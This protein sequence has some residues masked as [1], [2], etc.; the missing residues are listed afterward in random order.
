MG[1]GAA[2]ER[3][4][5][6]MELTLPRKSKLTLRQ[7]KTMLS[8]SNLCKCVIDIHCCVK[9][10]PGKIVFNHKINW[11]T[12]KWI[13]FQA[14]L[15]NFICCT[16]CML[17]WITTRLCMLQI[18]L[19]NNVSE[20]KHKKKNIKNICRQSYLYEPHM[21]FSKGCWVMQNGLKICS[22]AYKGIFKI[23]DPCMPT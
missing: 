19:L 2:D 18:N 11:D 4:G 5:A 17:Y 6:A 21:L 1:R 12:T 16:K 10:L 22:N 9:K 14:Y 23:Q 8:Y 7:Q 20:L 15:A 3:G 13:T